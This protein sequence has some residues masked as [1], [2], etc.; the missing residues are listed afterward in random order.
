M[1]ASRH[2]CDPSL[3]RLG[4]HLGNHLRIRSNHL[5][6]RSNDRYLLL[7]YALG[8][9]RLGNHLSIAGNH[10]RIAGNRRKGGVAGVPACRHKRRR[11]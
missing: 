11:R 3:S 9:D 1:P 7:V 10:L 6:T 5:R 2:P 4:N 8:L